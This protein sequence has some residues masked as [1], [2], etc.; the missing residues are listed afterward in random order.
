[1]QVVPRLNVGGVERG[2]VEFANYLKQQGHRSIVVSRGGELVKQLSNAGVEHIELEVAAKSLKTLKTIS[3]LRKVIE[4]YQVDVIHA[5]SRIPAWLCLHALRKIQSKPLFVTTLHGLHSVNRY[6]SVMARGDRVIAVSEVAKTYLLTHF[7]KYLKRQPIVIHRGVDSQFNQQHQ[8][9]QPWLEQVEA[10]F[11]NYSNVN[12]VLL[13]GRLSAV[14]GVEQVLPWLQQAKEDVKLVLTADINQSNYSKKIAQQLNKLNI[15]HKVIWL[16]TI[17]NMP[18]LYASVDLVISVNNKPESFGRTVLEAL[19]MGKP[20]V[21]YDL[22]GVGELM[23]QLFPSGLIKAG[24]KIALQNT[25]NQFLQYP[26]KVTVQHNFHN[27]VMFE[28]TLG[29]YQQGLAAIS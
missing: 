22:G 2:T 11:P 4:Q 14:K 18:D 3:L 5:R 25:I 24:D 16:G 9:N 6:S 21:A 8:I 13:P 12:K 27:K 26:P 23:Q 19:S 20:V 17:A 15:E 7:K 1:M 29:V 28:K 10:K